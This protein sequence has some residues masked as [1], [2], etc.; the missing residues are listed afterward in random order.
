MDEINLFG[1][2]VLSKPGMITEKNCSLSEMKFF[3]F[4]NGIPNQKN[5]LEKIMPV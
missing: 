1:S 4:V 3:C 2:D 5:E